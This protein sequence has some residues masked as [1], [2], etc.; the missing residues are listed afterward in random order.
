MRAR[1]IN[2]NPGKTPPCPGGAQAHAKCMLIPAGVSILTAKQ[3]EI[4]VIEISVDTDEFATE[5]VMGIAR[6]GGWNTS[7]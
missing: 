6:E 7:H 1:G 5:S 3:G 2:L 4:R